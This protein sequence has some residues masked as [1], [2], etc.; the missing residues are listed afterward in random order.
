MSSRL[1]TPSPKALA[2]I[3][4]ILLPTA[5][6]SCPYHAPTLQLPANVEPLGHPTVCRP[7]SPSLL[8]IFKFFRLLSSITHVPLPVS[9]PTTCLKILLLSLSLS[10]SRSDATSRNHLNSLANSTPPLSCLISSLA[11]LRHQMCGKTLS[12]YEQFPISKHI[13]PE[14]QLSWEVSVIY[15]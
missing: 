5:P 6:Q 11:S 10:A 4:N 3:C 8:I 12:Y 14:T 15:V 2:M 7:N 13:A 1:L 9:S